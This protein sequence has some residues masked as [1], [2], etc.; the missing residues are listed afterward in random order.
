[1]IGLPLFESK[2]SFVM[3]AK[4]VYADIFLGGYIAPAPLE[5][6]AEDDDKTGGVIITLDPMDK[7]VT[8]HDSVDTMVCVS[9]DISGQM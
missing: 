6:V 5:K 4:G 3:V 7:G 1:M 9:P 2:E 8:R